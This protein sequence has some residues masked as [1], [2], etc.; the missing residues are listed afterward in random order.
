MDGYVINNIGN[1]SRLTWAYPQALMTTSRGL[2]LLEGAITH[3]GDRPPLS[4]DRRE[5]LKTVNS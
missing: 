1:V 3:A 2:M 5:P 4:E